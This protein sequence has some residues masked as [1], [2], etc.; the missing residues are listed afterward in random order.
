MKNKTLLILA[1]GMGSRFGGLKQAEKFGPNGEY[2]I[3]YSIYD[4]LRCGF[5]KVVF[6]IKE[7]N[8]DLFRETVGKRIEGKIDVKYVFQ[9]NDNVPSQYIIP[10]NRVKPLGTAHAVLCAKNVI[11][12]PFLMINSDDFYG[13]DAFKVASDFI[14]SNS[15]DMAI[16]GYK[17]ENTITENGAVKRG[18]LKE[19]NGNLNEIIESSIEKKDGIIYATPLGTNN[20]KEINK[21]TKVSMNMIAFLPEF[22]EFIE[23][24]FDEFLK[25]SNLEKDEY[26]IPDVVMKAIN[27]GYCN[28][29]V[30]ETNSKWVGVTYKEDKDSVTNYIN[31]LIDK[32]EYKKDLWS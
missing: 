25:N 22:F 31:E 14:D 26:L 9:K 18:V 7:E 28:V 17:V 29:K 30:I 21:D 16:I 27:T 13:Y 19:T 24:N 10:D 23:N 3:D 20:S 12:E 6:I 5:N 2:I 4:A 1:A 8:Y 11:N 15:K 32:K